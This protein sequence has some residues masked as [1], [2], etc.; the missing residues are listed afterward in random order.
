M[1]CRDFYREGRKENTKGL[2]RVAFALF[3]PFA[4]KSSIYLLLLQYYFTAL[5]NIPNSSASR[6]RAMRLVIPSLSIMRD[7]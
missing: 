7:L 6:M 3:A 1:G 2:L 4:V 5:S